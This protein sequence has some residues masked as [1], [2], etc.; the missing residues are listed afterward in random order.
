MLTTRTAA[1]AIALALALTACTSGDD[2]PKPDPETPDVNVPE[3]ITL[4]SAGS[5]VPLGQSASVVFQP[6]NAAQTVITI[7][8][9]EVTRGKP[10]D[11]DGYDLDGLP[12]DS[13]PYYVNASIRNAGPAVIAG[14]AVPLYGVDSANSYF[15]PVD[16]RGTVHGCKPL[17]LGNHVKPGTVSKGCLVFAVPPKRTFKG[18]QVRTSDLNQPVTWKP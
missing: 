4:T 16:V 9:D 2:E 18:V 6:R 10:K 5:T 12:E 3:G 7:S 11:L 8:V 15:K 17:R 1:A 13:V 14:A